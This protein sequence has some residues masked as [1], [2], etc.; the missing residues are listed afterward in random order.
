MSEIVLHKVSITTDASGND[1][2]ITQDIDGFIAQ[3]RYVPAATNDL[4]ANWDLDIVGTKTGLV[5]ANI[6]NI[7]AAAITYAPRQA[8]HAV[9]GSA[10][11]YAATGEPVEGLIFV[12]GESLTVTVAQGGNAQSGTIWIWEVKP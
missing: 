2:V 4:D 11:L 6:D 7:S 9:D 3:I 8:T 5:V 12:G 1:E 10:S